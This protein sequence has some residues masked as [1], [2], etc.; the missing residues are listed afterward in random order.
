MTT[1]T[2]NNQ[3]IT[4]QFDNAL[5]SKSSGPSLLRGS[6]A[7]VLPKG[8]GCMLT[9]KHNEFGYASVAFLFRVD[10]TINPKEM[11][12]KLEAAHG[13]VNLRPDL[14]HEVADVRQS[15]GIYYRDDKF[16]VEKAIV[17]LYTKYCPKESFIAVG[18]Y[19]HPKE[20]NSNAAMK[21]REALEN[22]EKAL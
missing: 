13:L 2:T 16:M 10:P 8:A 7:S 5:Q 21:I 6:D 3:S 15:S 17:T 9:Y 22:L 14:K 4:S 19:G 12:L 11:E 18:V 1:V 20:W